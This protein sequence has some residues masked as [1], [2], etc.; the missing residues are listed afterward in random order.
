MDPMGSHKIMARVFVALS[1]WMLPGCGDSAQPSSAGSSVLQAT[2]GESN[3]A[4]VDR[5]RVVEEQTIGPR[6]VDLTIQS[7]AMG[8][9]TKVRLLLP[10]HWAASHR[11]WPVLYLLHG[12]CD[13]Y[14]SWTRETDVAALTEDLDVLVVMPEAGR[15]GWF[16]DW[17]NQGKGGPPR[18]ETFHLVELREILEHG[19]RA[20]PRR[21][22]AGL[23]MGGLGALTYAARHPGMFRAAATFSGVVD[24][25]FDGGPEFVQS[26][27]SNAGEDP[28]ALWGAPVAQRAIW[29]AH[30]PMD[31]A[32]RLLGIP[33]YVACG[34]GEPGPL[35]PP[36][37]GTDSGEHLFNQ[38]NTEL[39]QRL[40]ELGADA[41]INLYG[42]GTHSWPYWQ[43]ELHSSFPILMRAIGV[44]GS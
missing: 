33:L 28:L 15:A 2:E 42:P 6:T 19:Y 34:N 35:D 7:P 8:D 17:W 26:T 13:D 36:G 31:L 3:R 39:V 38:M 24:T 29:Q 22:I 20:G 12:C 30:N 37:R 4:P 43:R 1:L 11:K 5:A 41:T 32:H 23:S 16:S 21:A 40:R 25:Q 27:I 14:T 9:K 44:E 10:K 18:W